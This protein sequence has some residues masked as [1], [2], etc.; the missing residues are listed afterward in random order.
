[1]FNRLTLR[2]RRI[3]P[4]RAIHARRPGKPA[5][6]LA[7]TLIE[8]LIVVAIIAILA[9]IAVPNFLEAQIRAKVSR[10]K[11]DMRTV[12]IG[13]EAYRVDYG[14]YVDNTTPMTV[15]TT[16]IAYIP[17]LPEDAFFIDGKGPELPFP[18]LEFFAT[19]Y[20]YGAMP[21]ENPTH[22]V[23]SSLGPDTDLDTYLSGSADPI[24]LRFYPGYSEALFSDS[25]VDVNA[26]NF[27]YILYDPTNGTLSSGDVYRFGDRNVK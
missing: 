15:I 12:S 11:A 18:G 16:P 24:A 4:M 26:S 23:I 1:M 6:P 14:S 25:G 9:A 22:Y 5:M 8:L 7:F 17:V 21:V 13:V 10:A 27:R 20:G 2:S 3:P 19:L